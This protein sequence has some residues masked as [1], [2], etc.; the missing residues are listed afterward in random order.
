MIVPHGLEWSLVWWINEHV[1]GTEAFEG[2][3]SPT[4]HTD[5]I[6]TGYKLE[7]EFLVAGAA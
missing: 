2:P 1:Q 5:L 4:I 6:E 7:C 3:R